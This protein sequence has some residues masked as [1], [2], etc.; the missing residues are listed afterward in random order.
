MLFSGAIETTILPQISDW[1]SKGAQEQIENILPDAIT[2]SLF[3]VIPAF[4][5]VL[6]LSR[7]LLYYVFTP[8]YAAAW[9]I[10]IILIGG[11]LFEGID[12][13]FKTYCLEW[14][15]LIYGQ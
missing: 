8:A 15:D 4:F 6:I 2:A 3:F 9:P 7:D 13:I 10:L 14:I 12:R 5:G 11:K 1:D